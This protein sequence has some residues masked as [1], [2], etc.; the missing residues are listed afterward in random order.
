LASTIVLRHLRS[1]F[2]LPSLPTQ[3]LLVIWCV[4]PKRLAAAAECSAYRDA[5]GALAQSRAEGT[6]FPTRQW[7]IAA[8]E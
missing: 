4:A 1:C 8:T 7:A 3:C 5:A 2:P 6:G